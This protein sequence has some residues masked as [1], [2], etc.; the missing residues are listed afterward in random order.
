MIFDGACQL[1]TLLVLVEI[2][3]TVL[4]LALTFVDSSCPNKSRPLGLV[5]DRC[6]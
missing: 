2:K 4:W 3:L 5:L 6:D 1:P